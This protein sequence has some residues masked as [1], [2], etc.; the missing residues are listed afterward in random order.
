MSG[1]VMTSTSFFASSREMILYI[2]CVTSWVHRERMK[3]V[4]FL[5]ERSLSDT[6]TY[7]MDRHLRQVEEKEGKQRGKRI[8]KFQE[9]LQNSRGGYVYMYVGDQPLY[10]VWQS[11]FSKHVLDEVGKV[12]ITGVSSIQNSDEVSNSQVHFPPEVSGPD[13]CSTPFRSEH[14]HTHN[15]PPDCSSQGGTYLI[16]WRNSHWG[17]LVS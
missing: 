8:H 7:S 3:N 15:Q 12:K 11:Q 9:T 2:R 17:W 10:N 5:V 1:T 14:T 4:T 6:H 13:D 16:I